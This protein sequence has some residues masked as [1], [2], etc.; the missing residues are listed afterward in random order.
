MIGNRTGNA[1]AL[2][3]TPAELNRKTVRLI[4]QSDQRQNLRDAWTNF[5]AFPS[6]SFQT[7]GDV[8]RYGAGMHQIKV[9][10]NHAN[11]LTRFT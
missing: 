2:L 9:L 10:K 6:G 8:L 4:R 11:A 3:L 7:K 5:A 1:N